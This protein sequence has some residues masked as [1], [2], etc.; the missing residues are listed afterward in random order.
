M[1][2]CS[3]WTLILIAKFWQITPL[4]ALCITPADDN[5]IFVKRVI[6]VTAKIEVICE[7]YE[8]L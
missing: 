2:V 8:I 3:D 6:F 5:Y 1:K 7:V 4:P